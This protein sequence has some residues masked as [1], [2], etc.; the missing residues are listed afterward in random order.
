MSGS[1]HTRNIVLRFGR[2]A[3]VTLFGM[4]TVSALSICTAHLDSS[5]TQHHQRANQRFSIQHHVAALKIS[6]PQQYL[7]MV[8][9]IIHSRPPVVRICGFTVVSGKECRVELHK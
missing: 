4:H 9:A 1:H 2:D 7:C 8:S 3:C 6:I 5:S